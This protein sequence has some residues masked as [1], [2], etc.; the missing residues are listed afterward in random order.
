MWPEPISTEVSPALGRHSAA[1][2]SEPVLGDSGEAADSCYRVEGASTDWCT[3]RA[4]SVTGVRH[5]LAG[6]P[7]EDS[8]AWAR[9]G[10]HL[11]VA[12]ADGLGSV[13]GSGGAARRAA[14]AAVKSA[15]EA[16]AISAAGAVESGVAAANE[17]AAGSGATTLVVAV[18]TEDGCVEAGRVGDSTAFVVTDGGRSWVEVFARPDDDGEVGT[19][20]DALPSDRALSETASCRLDPTD[21]LVLATDGVADP[22]RD[23][24]LTVAPA[25]AEALVGHPGA[26]EL[27]RLADFSRQGCHDDRTLVCVWMRGPVE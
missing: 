8:F 10:A 1:A 19:E 22:W 7:G 20:T 17:A 6:Q 5:R 9:S 21:V 23:G 15:A 25:L 12:V 27:A 26:L 2:A 16:V 18:V 3:L 24:P 14:S 13:A 4:V 11:A